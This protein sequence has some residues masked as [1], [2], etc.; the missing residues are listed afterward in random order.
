METHMFLFSDNQNK[1]LAKFDISEMSSG[2]RL[3]VKLRNMNYA[4]YG[5]MFDTFQKFDEFLNK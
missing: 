4:E 2:Y 1:F 3:K 5:R